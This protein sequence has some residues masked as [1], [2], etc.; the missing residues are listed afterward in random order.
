[1]ALSGVTSKAYGS[2][3]LRACVVVF[4]SSR[5][6]KRNRLGRSVS[7]PPFHPSAA[8]AFSSGVEIHLR[9]TRNSPTPKR[10]CKNL[11]LF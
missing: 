4:M 6:P 8:T 11:L 3:R 1:M 10:L 5:H 2:L 7:P 9:R